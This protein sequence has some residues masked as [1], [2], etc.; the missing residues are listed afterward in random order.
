MKLWPEKACCGCPVDSEVGGV[1]GKEDLGVAFS[2]D[3]AVITKWLAQRSLF[4]GP[5]CGRVE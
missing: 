1:S 3:L 4:Q 2:F 5:W